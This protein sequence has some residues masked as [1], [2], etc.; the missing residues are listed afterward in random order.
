M[1]CHRPKNAKCIQCGLGV[2]IFSSTYQVA[3]RAIR[4]HGESLPGASL[5][6]SQDGRTGAADEA[7]H[8]GLGGHGVDAGLRGVLVEDG[9]KAVGLAI[10]RQVELQ[11]RYV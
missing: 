4:P 1:H 11:P 6:V 2:Q 9:V 8:R 7:P 10:V 3:S 5:S